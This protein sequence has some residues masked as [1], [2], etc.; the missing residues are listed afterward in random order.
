MHNSIECLN[1]WICHIV[2][3]KNVQRAMRTQ[4]VLYYADSRQMHRNGRFSQFVVCLLLQSTFSFDI[5][6]ANKNTVETT[7][8]TLS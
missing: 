7:M 2:V 8:F 1:R 5:W 6:G 4:Y 3:D